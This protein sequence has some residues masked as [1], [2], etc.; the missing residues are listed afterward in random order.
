MEMKLLEAAKLVGDFENV[1]L[2][3]R[4]EG[5]IGE[6]L[7]EVLGLD[8]YDGLSLVQAFLGHD[9][10]KHM[11][12]HPEHFTPQELEEIKRARSTLCLD[13]VLLAAT[14]PE[15]AVR[16]MHEH[17]DI[18]LLEQLMHYVDSICKDDDIVPL[19][20]RIAEVERRKPQRTAEFWDALGQRRY[21][22]V[23]RE[24][25]QE[26]EH[27][28]WELLTAA[29]CEIESPEQVP[30]WIRSELEARIAAYVPPEDAQ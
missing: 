28:I 21:W 14:K 17:D 18:S 19:M 25:G 22:D 9:Y 24:M 23:E 5:A 20:E 1:R 11:E 26:E 15:F 27:R 3:C 29:G 4:I 30:A 13:E 7:A 8:P 12:L 2:H 16:W 10:D 6:M